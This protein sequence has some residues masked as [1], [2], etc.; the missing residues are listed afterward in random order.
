M[1]PDGTLLFMQPASQLQ[2]VADE[3]E[4]FFLRT[5]DRDDVAAKG[6]SLGRLL[7]RGRLLTDGHQLTERANSW[8]G[9]FRALFAAP[10]AAHDLYS[11]AQY[12]R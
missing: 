4:A 2:V 10:H 8:I 12:A 11:A 7:V 3:A 5:I 6:Q 9:G 1:E